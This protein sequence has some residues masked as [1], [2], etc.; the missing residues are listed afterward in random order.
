MRLLVVSHYFWPENFRINDLVQEFIRRG[1]QVTVLTANT[2]GVDQLALEQYENSPGS[3]KSF[4]GAQVIRVPVVRR[5]GSIFR[6]LLNYS[7]FLIT[8]LTLGLRKLKGEQFDVVFVYQPSPITAGIPG[9]FFGRLTGAPVVLWVLDLWPDVLSTVTQIQSR[10]ILGLARAITKFIYKRCSLILIQSRAF[11]RSVE[12]HCL[13]ASK[14]R[15]FPSWSDVEYDELAQTRSPR[16]RNFEGFTVLFAGNLGEAQDIPSIL[17]AAKLT[18]HSSKIRW[19]IV[20]DGK[21]IK[22]LKREISRQGLGEIVCAPG[23]FALE[24]MPSVF[25]HA[26]ALLVSLK[27]GPGLNET[28]PGK[29]QSY[30]SAGIPLVGM[31]DGEAARVISQ[32]G[33]GFVC[34]SGDSEALA[35]TV[36]RLS[37]MTSEELER[38]G[39][40]ARS[41]YAEEFSRSMLMNKLERM[42]E[43]VQKP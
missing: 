36:V 42:L 32:S 34:S 25:A 30:L 40:N 10:Y 22:W 43:E 1:H 12:R 5:D 18:S 7:S 39:D 31:I 11:R 9:L 6:L 27:S 15:Y 35:A 20:G 17:K 37:R 4:K 16:I 26:D 38:F 19:V 8:S 28:I 2:N 24:E 41:Y 23:R 3:F 33:A 29:L 13:D 14:V 21:K